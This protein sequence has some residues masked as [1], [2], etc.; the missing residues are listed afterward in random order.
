[1]SQVFHI[2]ELSLTPQSFG[3]SYLLQAQHSEISTQDATSINF[4]SGGGLHKDNV[5][6]N[7]I[8]KKSCTLS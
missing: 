5:Y 4:I 2:R 8:D 6:D 7:T 1:M 3:K